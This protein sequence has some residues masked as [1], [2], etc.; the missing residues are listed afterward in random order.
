VEFASVQN[1]DL[2]GLR[3][4]EIVDAYYFERGWTTVGDAKLVKDYVTGDQPL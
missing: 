2:D 3:P 1:E 4:V